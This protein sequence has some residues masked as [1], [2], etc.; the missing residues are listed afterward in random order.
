MLFSI[1]SWS[2]LS[3]AETESCPF[4]SQC[5][6]DTI[7]LEASCINMGK[8][9]PSFGSTTYDSPISTLFIS[10]EFSSIPGAA[11]Y[12]LTNISRVVISFTTVVNPT[13]YSSSFECQKGVVYKSFEFVNSNWMSPGY[14]SPINGLEDLTYTGYSAGTIPSNQFNSLNLKT[15]SLPS[16]GISVIQTNAFSGLESTL[17]QLDLSNNPLGALPSDT[18]NGLSKLTYLDLSNTSL[19]SLPTLALK[20][21]QRTTQSIWLNNNN[22]QL[23]PANSFNGY[24]RLQEI[25]LDGNPISLIEIGAFYGLSLRTLTLS[26]LPQLKFVDALVTYGIQN[27]QTINIAD[28]PSLEVVSVSDVDKLPSSLQQVSIAGNVNIKSVDGNFNAWLKKSVEEF[29][30]NKLIIAGSRNFDCSDEIAWMTNFVLCFPQQLVLT[31]SY[32]A[33]SKQ[34]VA[35][36]L[37]TYL[38]TCA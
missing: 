31:D 21:V 16:N 2:S 28:C 34:L 35:D 19:L 20:S 17:T 24:S 27:V 25:G 14:L 32:C 8:Y 15:L 3:S 12:Y 9:W 1:A 33:Q 38:P 10:G 4:N 13:V 6:C 36:Y 29:R 30:K 37:K 5:T 18:F 22:I 26:N 7:T 23:I 11:I